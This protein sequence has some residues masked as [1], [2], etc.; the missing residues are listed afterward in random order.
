MISFLQK[1]S[2]WLAFASVFILSQVSTYSA[3]RP[4]SP[5][6]EIP[7]FMHLQQLVP[8]FSDLL[9][10]R[11]T[12]GPVFGQQLVLSP[13]PNLH[14]GIRA[15]QRWNLEWSTVSP[16]GAAQLILVFDPDDALFVSAVLIHGFLSEK[17]EI[18]LLNDLSQSSH[19]YERAKKPL[20]EVRQS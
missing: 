2:L 15:T 9:D 6:F 13:A 18:H 14:R 4:S 16:T 12:S 3:K 11:G 20:T 8:Y 19:Q 1:T 17:S 5:F 7:Y 10:L